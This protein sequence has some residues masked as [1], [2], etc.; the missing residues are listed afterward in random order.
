MEGH[1]VKAEAI[2]KMNK[3][4][5]YMVTDGPCLNVMVGF[6]AHEDNWKFSSQDFRDLE[7]SLW[8]PNHFLLNL[9]FRSFCSVI[10]S[11]RDIQMC[12]SNYLKIEVSS[13]YCICS[14]ISYVGLISHSRNCFWRVLFVAARTR[15]Q[16]TPYFDLQ[17][18]TF[19]P[20]IQESSPSKEHQPQ[21]NI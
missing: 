7:K 4:T 1:L 21:E 9:F 15:R 12:Y 20:I 2:G 3:T 14:P 6:C 5:W 16:M 8:D 19:P 10:C 13:C 11:L 18:H 17:K